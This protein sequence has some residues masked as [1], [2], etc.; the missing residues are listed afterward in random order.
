MTKLEL[1]LDHPHQARILRRP[2]GCERRGPPDHVEPAQV[3]D[4]GD[5]KR[6]ARVL[7]EFFDARPE[8]SLDVRR[9]RHEPVKDA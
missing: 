5:Q 8:R 1:R 2:Q 3:I 7:R 6:G 9:Y 4:S